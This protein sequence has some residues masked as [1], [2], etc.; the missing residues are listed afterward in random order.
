MKPHLIVKLHRPVAQRLPPWQDA[1]TTLVGALPDRLV[2]GID[3]LLAAAQLPVIVTSEHRPASGG[4]WSDEEVASGINRIYRLILKQN[5]A[6]PPRLIDQIQLLPDVEYVRLGGIGESPLPDRQVTA[7]SVRPERKPDPLHIGEAQRYSTG[8][9]TIRIAILDT[10]IDT[11]HPE[12]KHA[13]GPGMDFVNII[14][15]ANEFIGDFLDYD[16]APGDEVGHGT[17]VAG[18]VAGMGRQM[19]VGVV[20]NC[21]L[22]P[23]RVL[24]AMRN[25]NDVVGAGLIDNINTGIK[26]AVDQGV[27]LINMSLGIRHDGG[28]LPH[29]EVIDYALR[30]GVTVV[31]ASGNDGTKASYYP[32]ALPGVIAVGAI[33]EHDDMAPFS[34]YGEQVSFVAPGTNIYSSYREHGYAFASGTSQAAPFVTGSIA[35]LKSFARTRQR[36]LTDRQVKYLLKRT[37][38][39]PDQRLRTDRWGYGRINLLDAVR[40]LDYKLGD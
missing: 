22:L 38:D 2:P 5:Q 40:L 13:L 35:L 18:I 4:A 6:I 3:E 31:A 8:D 39:R 36:T 25:G 7:Q 27:D 9:P 33:D 16:E 12:I 15:G 10:G 11:E 21:K 29:A 30:K 23:V 37:A 20:P 24:G 17:H 28:G 19:P 1:L 32:G 26:W 14:D 34:T